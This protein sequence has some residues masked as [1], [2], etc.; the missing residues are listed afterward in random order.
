MSLIFILYFFFLGHLPILFISPMSSE[1]KQ[2]T[3]TPRLRIIILTQTMV[4]CGDR[5]HNTSFTENTTIMRIQKNY[6]VKFYALTNFA[7]H[8]TASFGI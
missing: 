7:S 4:P 2:R 1:N 6:T 3:E 8:L 5:T